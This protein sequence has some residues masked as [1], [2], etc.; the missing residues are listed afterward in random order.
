MWLAA[1]LASPSSRRPAASAF[2]S[3]S[4]QKSKIQ[5]PQSSIGNHFFSFFFL[6]SPP[7]RPSDLPTFR[8]SDPF[9]ISLT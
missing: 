4:I 1:S 8:P 3:S 2:L 5:N 6:F 7:L 9:F